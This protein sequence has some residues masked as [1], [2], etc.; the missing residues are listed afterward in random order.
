[1][2]EI[3]TILI[4]ERNRN[5]RELLRRELAAEGYRI[6]TAGCAKEVDGRLP[7]A[8]PLDAI[9]LDNDMPEA[10]R[11]AMVR[12]IRLAR[13]NLPVIVHGHGI[14][15]AGE[16]LRERFTTFVKKSEDLSRLKAAV[17][18]VLGRN[19]PEK[20]AGREMTDLTGSGGV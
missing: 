2:N 1:M 20:Y 16:A 18:G 19:Q 5:V 8:P 12:K 6:E 10:G 15:E 14:E 11:A 4:A 17:A 9:V 13:P 3:F 7:A